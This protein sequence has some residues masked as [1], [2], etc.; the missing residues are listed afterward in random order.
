MRNLFEFSL[1]VTKQQ[2]LKAIQKAYAEVVDSNT[3][4]MCRYKEK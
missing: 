2:T 1:G 3:E 4:F